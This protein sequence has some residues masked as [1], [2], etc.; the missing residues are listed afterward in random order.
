MISMPMKASSNPT[1]IPSLASL[2]NSRVLIWSQSNLAA[3]T[4][5]RS[6]RKDKRNDV[7]VMTLPGNIPGVTAVVNE[8]EINDQMEIMQDYKDPYHDLPLHQTIN[9]PLVLDDATEPTNKPTNT[10]IPV[11]DDEALGSVLIDG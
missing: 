7:V 9:V 2:L 1:P 8:I 11:T 3:T 4:L 10:V 6:A 5:L